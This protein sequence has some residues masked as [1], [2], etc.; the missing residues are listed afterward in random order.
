MGCDNGYLAVD[1]G[2][3][4]V[5]N[6]DSGVDTGDSKVGNEDTGVDTGQ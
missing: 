4:A 5:N 2:D 3:S 6:L 1:T